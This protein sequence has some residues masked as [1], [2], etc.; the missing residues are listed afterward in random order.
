MLRRFAVTSLVLVIVIITESSLPAWAGDKP[1]RQ[2]IDDQI[3]LAWKQEKVV[4]VGPSPDAEFLRRI[5]LDLVG[6][7]PNYDET[8]KFLNDDNPDK[9][10]KLIDRLLA[11][12]RFATHQSDV[13]DLLFFGRNPPGYDAT[14]KRD[15]FKKWLTDKFAGNVAYDQWVKDLLLAEQ[16]GPE[17]FYVQFRNQPEEATVAV[18]RIF[19][20]TQLQCARCHDHPFEKLTQ[21]DFYGMAGFFVRL[22]VIDPAG[23]KKQFQ[24]AE[25]SSGEVLF[26]GSVKD[27]KPGKKGVP[28]Q[29]KFLN[30]PELNEPPLPQGFKEPGFKPG[31]KPPTPLFSRKAKLAAWLTAPDNP[32]FARAAANRVWAQ[33]MGRGLVHP[34]DNL[35]DKK[36]ASHPELLDALTRYLVDNK[37]DLKKFIRELVNSD[38]YQLGGAGK[39]KEAL[40]FWFERAPV[41][42][43]TAE[44][45][46]A[47]F[48]TATGH[49]VTGDKLP[50]AIKEYMVMYFGQ[51]H[52]GQGDFQ[53][54]L[55]EH[56]FLN[57]SG[58]LRAMIQPRKGNLADKLL[59]SKASWEDKTRQMFLAVLSRPP[60]AAE[61]KR[62]VEH[63]TSDAKAAPALMEEAIWVLVSCS[64]FRFNH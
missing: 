6:T 64:E 33:Y 52:D 12:P 57:N 31:N 28:V 38:T 23:G 21:R 55:A 15:S 25:K 54:S 11:D 50:G 26:S 56:L 63:F 8:E 58:D 35:S 53:G 47:A 3:R 48:R 9:R 42:P 40:P 29:P 51:P 41:R 24:I 59:K 34:V 62:F 27:Q 60:S 30:G 10:A 36:K 32:Y 16:E 1:L 7:I 37:F 2:I 19:L 4:P 44:Q 13:W 39:L 45:L 14:R 61:S 22:V 46:L 5:Y 43:L 20:G 49:D 17:L 18:T